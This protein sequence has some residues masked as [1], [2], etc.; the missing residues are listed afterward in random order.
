MGQSEATTKDKCKN[1]THANTKS[2]LLNCFGL[3]Q[4]RAKKGA[5]REAAASEQSWT[6][7]ATP[8]DH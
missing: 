5:G 3:A 1:E 7:A 4:S 2:V 8:I 6:V